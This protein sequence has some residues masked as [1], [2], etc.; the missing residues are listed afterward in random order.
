MKA[1]LYVH[2]PKQ[3]IEAEYKRIRDSFLSRPTMFSTWLS[4]V[5]NN[6]AQLEG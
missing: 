2:R 4:E 3:L 1:Y 6:H 5:G